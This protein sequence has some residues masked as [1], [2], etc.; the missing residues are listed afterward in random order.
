MRTNTL[1][2]VKEDY[3]RA[4]F[5]IQEKNDQS[6]KLVNIADRLGL[7]RSTVTERIQELVAQGYLVRKESS[8]IAFTKRGF[9]VA[10]KLT[11]KHRM[12]EVF[13]HDV[14]HI[15][16]DKVHAEAHKLEHAMSDEVIKKL[17]FFLGNP[18]YDSHGKPIPPL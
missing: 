14:L 18:L 15:P 16:K 13:L 7:S 9:A 12:I 4:I 17:G 6:T 2:A 8:K 3:L 5:L 1:T 10:R 11:H